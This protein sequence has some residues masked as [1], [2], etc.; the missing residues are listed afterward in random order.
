M[1]KCDICGS[2]DT[3]PLYAGITKCRR[4]GHAFCRIE[5]AGD[6]PDKL[7]GKGYFSGG[8]K[9]EYSDYL[10][11][12]DIIQENFKLRLRILE[13]FLN[14]SRHK[15]LLEI[16][17]AYGLFLDIVRS[18]FDTAQGIDVAEGA[19]SYAKEK[20][21]LDVMNAD[22]CRHDFTGMEFDMVCMW[23]TIEH[24]SSPNSCLKK[25][26]GLMKSGGLIAITTGD[27]G[28][29]NARL[30]GDRWRLLHSPS[31]MHFFSRATLAKLLHDSGFDI[32]YDGY[33]GFIRSFDMALY[34]MLAR[35]K[36]WSVIYKFL[37]DVGIT[38]FSFY[39]NF[40]DI[41]YVIA[42]KR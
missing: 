15:R 19:T 29:L 7:Y 32:V 27:I 26:S 34:R 28:S 35:R 39:S 17:S 18:R 3:S 31:H 8:E 36:G 40:F 37:K 14:P 30:R 13:K 20:L 42:L 10:A 25:I 2:S 22:F 41:M 9:G 1:V 21:G 33:C 12:R 4:C 24:L 23:D 5:S 11:D 16:G 6:A 38:R